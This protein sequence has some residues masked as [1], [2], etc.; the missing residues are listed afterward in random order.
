MEN[1]KAGK[2]EVIPKSGEV[3]ALSHGLAMGLSCLV[4]YV[5]V[6]HVYAHFA[7]ITR[8][9][10]LLGAMWATVA[11]VF[12]QRIT[13]Q[14][15]LTAALSRLA[16]TGVSFVLCLIYLL[17]LPF[18]AWGLALLI[19]LGTIIMTVL[20]RPQ[21]IVTTGITTAVVMV[22]ANL[23]PEHRWQQPPLRLVDTIIGT[24]IGAV[25]GL[26]EEATLLLLNRRSGL[27]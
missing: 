27:K 2:P 3:N 16:A 7:F 19:A 11:T 8:D 18:H 25:G 6:S 23:S 17:L 21:D 14:S 1:L 10:L 5:F 22:V 12:V 13:Y 9:N 26:L 20:R 24:G 15:S 4:T